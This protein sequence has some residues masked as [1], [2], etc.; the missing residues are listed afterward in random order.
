MPVAF[1]TADQAGRYGRYPGEPTPE[2]LARFV[3]RDDADRALVM[4]RQGDPLRLG[5][6]LQLGPVRFL[7]TL[8]AA[9]TDVPPGV[10]SHRSRPLQI[11]APAGFPRYLERLPPPYAHAREMQQRDG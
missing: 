8:L 7:G 1:L 3:Y 11:A 5:V 9:P 6:A 4:R 10:V 2:Q